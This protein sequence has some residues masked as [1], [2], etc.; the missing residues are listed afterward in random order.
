MMMMMI[1]QAEIGWCCMVTSWV[2]VRIFGG[3][4]KKADGAP[5]CVVGDKMGCGVEHR[6]N[7]KRIVFFTHNSKSVSISLHCLLA[8][9]GYSTNFDKQAI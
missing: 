8:S 6:S 7:G 1:I 5:V 4:E 9:I 2:C 3:R